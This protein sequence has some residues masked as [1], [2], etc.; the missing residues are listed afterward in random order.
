MS[1]N[2]DQLKVTFYTVIAKLIL[3]TK[4][5]LLPNEQSQSQGSCNLNK[6]IDG[7][8]GGM[9]GGG[10]IRLF[11]SYHKNVLPHLAW[12]GR[13]LRTPLCTLLL[14]SIVHAAIITL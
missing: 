7:R 9:G 6:A 1:S 14:H 12:L 13:V 3:A 5:I 10:E 2:H 8:E 4:F 11:V